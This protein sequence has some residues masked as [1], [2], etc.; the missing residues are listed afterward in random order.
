MKKK[1][2]REE[3]IK[4]KLAKISDTL[5]VIEENLPKDFDEFENSRLI[6][7]AVYK[8]IEF[9]I[10]TI[11]DICNIIN[12]DLSLGI[13]ETE[14]TIINNLEKKKIFSKSV[15]NLII[16]MKKFRN[17]LIH[18]YGEIDDE[19]AFETIR[20]GLK[21]IEFIIKEVEIFLKKH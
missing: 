8:E 20:D 9:S 19:L 13:P 6:R 1:V 2:L 4:S 5:D 15:I 12:K 11:L 7:D 10:E 17:I 18:K 14:E 3:I 16:E 21:D